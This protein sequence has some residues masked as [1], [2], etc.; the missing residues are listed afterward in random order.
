MT[1][2]RRMD[3]SVG[4]TT[5]Q[6]TPHASGSF[7]NRWFLVLTAAGWLTAVLSARVRRGALFA[8]YVSVIVGIY[9]LLAIAVEPWIPSPIFPLRQ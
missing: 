4:R 7:L 9:S 8:T 1:L 6:S 2:C 5:R 3:I